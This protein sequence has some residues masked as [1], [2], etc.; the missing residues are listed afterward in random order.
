MG[1]HMAMRYYEIVSELNSISRDYNR[2]RAV[3]TDNLNSDKW[4]TVCGFKYTCHAQCVRLGG[5]LDRL[6]IS[7]TCVHRVTDDPGSGQIHINP[8]KADIACKLFKYWQTGQIV[9]PQ[10]S[11]RSDRGILWNK[12]YGRT[13]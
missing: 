4:G 11:G 12:L 1:A 5:L 10:Y 8:K 9:T 7:H 13:R 6:N 3:F 2:F